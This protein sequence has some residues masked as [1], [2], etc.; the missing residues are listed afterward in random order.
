M[1][2]A[3]WLK[4]EFGQGQDGDGVAMHGADPDAARPC[5]DLAVS[6]LCTYTI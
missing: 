1:P 4:V 6:I 5:R 3:L 2:A